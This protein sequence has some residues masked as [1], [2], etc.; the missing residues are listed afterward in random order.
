MAH[1]FDVQ[2][3][4][5]T[6]GLI[7]GHDLAVGHANDRF[8]A[9]YAAIPPSRF[10]GAM[11][12]WQASSPAHTLGEYTFIDFGCGKGRAALLASELGFREVVGVELNTKLAEIAQ[13]NVTKWNTQGK[14]KSPIRI[15]CGDALELEWPAGPCLV[16]LYNPFAEPVMRRLANKMKM[17]F[18]TNP[19]NLEIVYQKPEH[20]EVFQNDFQMVWCE[21]IPM[22]EDDRH[23]EFVAS[24]TDESRAYRL[25]I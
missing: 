8:I 22:S 25:S 4:V 2:N 17:H 5:T 11:E 12:R 18:G 24:P 6:D 7:P 20:A 15:V 19:T 1:P 13:T 16:Y 3:M 9:G 14:A 23:A 10:Y 21:V